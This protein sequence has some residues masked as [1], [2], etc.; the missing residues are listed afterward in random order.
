MWILVGNLG[1]GAL[2]G[3]AYMVFVNTLATPDEEGNHTKKIYLDTFRAI[4]LGTLAAFAFYASWGIDLTTIMRQF[5]LSLLA[6]FSF[7]IVWQQRYFRYTRS[8]TNRY[9]SPLEAFK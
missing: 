3:F 7:E 1:M 5:L 2:G 8:D 4:F 9:A 6:G